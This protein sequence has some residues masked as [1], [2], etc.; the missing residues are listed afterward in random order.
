MDLILPIHYICVMK[1]AYLKS[2]GTNT[3][4]YV[5]T[6][7]GE[8]LDVVINNTTYLANTAEEFYLMYSS[9][10][11][12]LKGSTDVRM[13]LFAALLER[14]S[15]GQEFSMSKTLKEIMANECECKP[16]SFD[17][18]FTTLI[19]DNIIIRIGPLTYKINPRHVFQ[20]SSNE[21][22]K[23]L[24]AILELHCKDC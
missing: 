15:R 1:K 19:K 8:V 17:L 11:L 10:V 22:N 14:Y 9:M 3:T 13:K 6:D 23:S 20:G 16:R 21:R 18:A 24:K 7:T 5:D 12:I 2:S 4:E